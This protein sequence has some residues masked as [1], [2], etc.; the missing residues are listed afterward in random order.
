MHAKLR[1][2]VSSVLQFAETDARIVAAALCGSHAR[3]TARAD[4]DIDFVFVSSDARSLLDNQNWLEFFGTPEIVGVEDY[5]LV[6][7][8]RVS[9][10]A[11]EVEFGIAGLEWASHPIDPGTAAVMREPMHIFYDPEGL[12]QAAVA[13]V[14]EKSE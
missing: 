14:N 13:S 5:G 9:Y 8:V 4:S 7:S 2:L 1:N 12:L 3:G 10:D 11:T 6:Q